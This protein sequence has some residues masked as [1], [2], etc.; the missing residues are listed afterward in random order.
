[1]LEKLAACLLAA[2]LPLSVGAAP[3]AYTIDPYHT[4]PHFEL[5][6]MGYMWIRGR[7]DKT[8]GAFT[9]DTAAKTGTVQLTI[10]TATVTTGDNV[11][12]ER[13]RSRDD[14][15]VRPTSSTSRS[16]LP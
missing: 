11:R 8:T 15:C 13:A 9:I 2:A 1:M 10:E 16:F 5:D 14:T 6:H 4:F 7:F 12:G 3:E